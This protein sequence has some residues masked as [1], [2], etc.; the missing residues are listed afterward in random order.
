[1]VVDR[2]HPAGADLH[3]REVGDGLVRDEVQ[4]GGIGLGG[5]GRPD[6]Q[7]GGGG[8]GGGRDVEHDRGDAVGGHPTHPGHVDVD[9]L[10]GPDRREGST[11]ALAG[12]EDAEGRQGVVEAAGGGARR[13]VGADD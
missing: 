12:V 1:G 11:G 4:G 7:V 9:R 8:G 13:P 6:L 10:L 5:P 2:D 3:D